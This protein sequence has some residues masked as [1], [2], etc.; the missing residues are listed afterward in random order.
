MQN[1]DSALI[2]NNQLIKIVVAVTE[3]I[4]SYNKRGTTQAVT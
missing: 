2:N 3:L 4:A 1:L